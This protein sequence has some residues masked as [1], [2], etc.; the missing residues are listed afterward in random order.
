[1]RLGDGSKYL[2]F[3]VHLSCQLRGFPGTF[4]KLRA[5]GRQCL[6]RERLRDRTKDMIAEGETDGGKQCLYVGAL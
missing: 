5:G 3:H 1:M 2:F 4:Y 6:I